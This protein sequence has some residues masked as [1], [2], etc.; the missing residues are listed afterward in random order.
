M[1]AVCDVHEHP[2]ADVEDRPGVYIG[3]I[4]IGSGV[5]A[6]QYPLATPCD[7]RA[8]A[9]ARELL[10]CLL[11]KAAVC[12]AGSEV[13]PDDRD[14]L[15]PAGFHRDGVVGEVCPH[16]LDHGQSA[17][18]ENAARAV[19]NLRPVYLAALVREGVGA[20]EG[21]GLVNGV[22]S[23]GSVH[24]R[25][26][27]DGKGVPVAVYLGSGCDH[28]VVDCRE[29]APAGRCDQVGDCILLGI[30]QGDGAEAGI[31]AARSHA[32]D[33][34]VRVELGDV[35]LVVCRHDRA[36][37]RSL[38]IHGAN[39][40]GALGE[41]VVDREVCALDLFSEHEGVEDDGV[42]LKLAAAAGEAHALGGCVLFFVD[43]GIQHVDHKD[44]ADVPERVVKV[45]RQGLAEGERLP[46]DRIPELSLGVDQVGDFHRRVDDAGLRIAPN[47]VDRRRPDIYGGRAG[48]H[49]A[50]GDGVTDVPICA[51]EVF[52]GHLCVLLIKVLKRPARPLHR[53]W[54]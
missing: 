35:D 7:R 1:E 5:A 3:A 11:V 23:R 54:L 33:D 29:F 12:G 38:G 47:K 6:P 16:E 25:D 46:V 34:V 42:A 53:N 8:D 45:R 41:I 26:V 36:S 20:L 4:G 21:L 30:E 17:Q 32:A 22:D 18:V 40:D 10:G 2:H 13:L 48:L 14:L 44:R 24:D 19:N 43:V 37:Q 49:G 50:L 52:V 39:D 31:N 51:V 15:V 28:G 27:C 9:D